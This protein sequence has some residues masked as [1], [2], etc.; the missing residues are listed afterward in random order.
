MD[1]GDLL[2]SLFLR[3]DKG[4]LHMDPQDPGVGTVRRNP[5]NA[6]EDLL[7]IR[8]RQCHGGGAEGGNA[9]GVQVGRNPGKSLRACVAEV[10][11]HCA[12]DMHVH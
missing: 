9:I 7:Q 1:M 8:G 6:S 11:P 5:L 10:M 2:G 12:M 4:P 3:S